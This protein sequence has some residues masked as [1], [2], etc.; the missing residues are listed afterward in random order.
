MLESQVLNIETYV[1]LLNEKEIDTFSVYPK[2]TYP[3]ISNT[4][5]HVFGIH[6][7]FC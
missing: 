3:N 1:I 2:N 7:S 4:F 6:Q 5:G